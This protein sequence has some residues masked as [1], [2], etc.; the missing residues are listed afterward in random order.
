[1][2]DPAG[3][4]RS[5]VV[6]IA[7]D[8]F[9]GSLT[10]VEVARALAS[11]WARA[12]SRDEILLAPL[13]DGGEGTTVAIEAAG[14]WEWRV[15]DAT[16]PIGRAISARWLQSEDGSKAVIEL[17][18]ASGL[19][20]LAPDELDPLGA[21]TRGTGELIVAAL[22]AGVREITLGIGGSATNDG[23]A[24][25][26]RALG[27]TVSPADAGP[28]TIDLTGLDPRL[29]DVRFL[30]ACDVTNPLL[31][32]TGAAA[33]Y[34]PQKGASADDVAELDGRLAGYADALEAATGRH[35]RET[36]GAGAAGGTGFGLLSL[37]DRFAALE[38]VP[39]IDVAMEAADFD[40]KLGRADLVITGEGRIDAQTAFGKTAL[41]VARRAA[42]AG[43]ACI[44]VGGG[45]EPEGIEALRPLRA[46]VV[47]VV[48]R[49]QTIAQ[50]MAAGQDPLERCGERLA[51]L[52]DL[53][54]RLGA[55]SRS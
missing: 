52:V 47:P 17:A 50:A 51:R 37:R 28:V 38:L 5:L 31:G 20:R 53:G 24:G 41:G 18:A 12:R 26:L 9:K 1:V 33:T 54:G 42:G 2:T 14:G 40:G 48:E 29:S 3:D 10:S 39:G 36:P 25:I 44:A 15:A 22:D 49:P 11:G 7:P 30:I 45:V 46:V 6:L 27:A 55:S 21:T 34:G 35:E 23:G 16:D 4:G 13:A 8:S 43:V 19:S 32:P